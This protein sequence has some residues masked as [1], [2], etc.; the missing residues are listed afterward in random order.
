MSRIDRVYSH[1]K[2]ALVLRSL[3]SILEVDSNLAKFN[4]ALPS[5]RL[6]ILLLGPSPSS[7]V[8]SLIL[9]F[10]GLHLAAF[11]TFLRKLELASFWSILNIVLPP[12]WD[13]D[14]QS[15][16]FDLL[17]GRFKST[18]PT[19]TDNTVKCSAVLPSILSALEH[20]LN[21]MLER[22]TYVGP[23]L[24]A[25]CKS[26]NGSPEVLI[27]TRIFSRGGVENRLSSREPA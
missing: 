7:T 21:R 19:P 6:A 15:A 24:L 10:I 11:G 4:A 17:L 20:G 13:E 22:S 12:A 25:S 8:T 14:V 5:A 23:D 26:L 2:A 1:E 16:A 3:V 27:L 18:A 9:R